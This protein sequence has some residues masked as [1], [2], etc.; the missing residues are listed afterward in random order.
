MDTVNNDPLAGETALAPVAETR[1]WW[2]YLDLCRI[3]AI[4]CVILIHLVAYP[5][6]ITPIDSEDWRIL[7]IYAGATRW[8][9]PLFVMV[10]GALFLVPEKEL[11][12]GR[13][14]ARYI[15]R[16]AVALL[17][18]SGLFYL[19]QHYNVRSFA[20]FMNVDKRELVLN[21]LRGHPWHHW[22]IFMIAG[23]FIML[24][25]LKRIAGD[26][27][28]CRYYLILWFV[29]Q[30][31]VPMLPNLLSAVNEPNRL[32]ADAVGLLAFYNER[33]LP[34]LVVGY[35]GY[36]LLGY[37]LHTSSISPRAR[38]LVTALGVLG[39]VYTIKLT[40]IASLKGG[41]PTAIYQ[42]ALFANSGLPAAAI[43]INAKRFIP[44]VFRG[45]RLLATVSAAS[46]GVFLTH[47]LV[48]Y[49]LERNGLRI[50]S[51]PVSWGVPL[52]VMA[53]YAISLAIALL[54]RKVPV[55]R[56]YIT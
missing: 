17:F 19:I 12:L 29:L 30:G 16:F 31:V 2:P 51:F 48:S 32:V 11:S 53:I 38:W 43:M 27:N 6:Q 10:S 44:R 37:Y 54:I 46:F 42:D 40:A 41:A 36:F 49:A 50:E 5:W 26:R 47:G 24:P 33:L 28:V 20:D 35:P 45:S 52:I 39:I 34:S 7:N 18:W 21:I 3:L 22:F 23:I 56:E 1:R 25:I 55:V 15:P 9:V 4:F 8:C 13:L 14:Y